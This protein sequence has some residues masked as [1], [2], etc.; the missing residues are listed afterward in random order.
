MKAPLVVEMPPSMSS[1]LWYIALT[2]VER[3]ISGARSALPFRIVMARDVS[4][5]GSSNDT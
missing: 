3:W 4:R 5:S 2:D 1:S